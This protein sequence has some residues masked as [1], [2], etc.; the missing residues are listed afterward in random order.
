M[1]T[2]LKVNDLAVRFGTRDALA[3]VSF[4]L[5]ANTTTV[6]LGSNGAGKSTL[7][8]CILGSLAPRRGTI[9]VLGRDPLRDATAVQRS[10]GY[11]PDEPDVYGWMTARELMRF[12]REHY[13]YW[14]DER[15]SRLLDRLDVPLDTRFDA[16][17]RGE[18]SKAML[19]AALAPAP[20]L[21]LLDEPFARLAPPVRDEVLRAF[22]EEAPFEGGA[23][24]VATHDL[25]VAARIADRVLVLDQG[26]LSAGV[27]L[28]RVF[29]GR[30]AQTNLPD[31]LRALYPQSREEVAVR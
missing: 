13:P 2:I 9:G 29:D 31:A 10:I 14:S 17:S 5:A 20:R 4:E 25:E 12:L 21:I 3:G 8:R 22:V 27:E 23:A 30:G 28:D 26:R 24:L 18:A 7:M 6:L 1:N 11:V 15:A 16:M 19:A